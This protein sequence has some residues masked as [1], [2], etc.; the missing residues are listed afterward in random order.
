MNDDIY[1]NNDILNDKYFE[2]LIDKVVSD[3]EE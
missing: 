3:N 1:S 2:K